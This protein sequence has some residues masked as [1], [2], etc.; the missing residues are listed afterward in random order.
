M[1]TIPT[2][3]KATP[4]DSAGILE[5]LRIAF[6]PYRSS[7]PPEAFIDTVIT[8]DDLQHRLATMSLFVAVSESGEIVG[9]I[10]CHVVH[11]EEGHLR[12]MAVL[13]SWQ[14]SGVAEQLLKSAESELRSEGCSRISLDTTEPLVKAIRF[15][16]KHGFR[17]SGKDTY[18]CGM[19]RLEFVKN[20]T[21]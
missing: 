3:R 16:E 18:F 1:R 21:E 6:E 11:P 20:V 8:P 12:G 15:Y 7:Y 2:I 9:T 14:G 4:A 17:N 13:P 10:A 19:R 5:C